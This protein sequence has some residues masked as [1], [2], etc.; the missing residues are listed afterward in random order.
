MKAVVYTAPHQFSVAQVPM[1]EPG[2]GRLRLRVLQSGLCGTDL[3]LDAGEFMAAFPMTPGHEVVGVVDALGDGVDRFAVGQQVT[4]NPNRACGHCDFCREGRPILC[5]N[6]TGLGTNLPGFFAEYAV[7]PADQVY[8]AEG[9]DPDLAVLTEP[10]SCAV[11]GVETAA[12]RPGSSALVIG[13]GPTGLLLSQ[14]LAT[15]GATRVAVA[16]P[17]RFKLDTAAAL[18]ADLVIE[19]PRDGV[20][21]AA[22][23]GSSPTGDGFDLVVEATGSAAV[24]QLCVPLTR[25]GGTT[26][27]Y[28][29][30]DPDAAFSVN[31]YDVFRREISVKGSFAEITSFDA[32]L[33]ALRSGRVRGGVGD[34]QLI[35]HRFALDDYGA[36]L[37][38]LRS[39]KTAHKIII[40]P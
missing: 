24:A 40:E 9:L 5:P 7:A 18:G 8:D 14:L 32:A 1:P 21:V 15:G 33:A 35:T 2:P 12:V 29:V 3:H 37:Q 22:L 11:H 19:I 27:I 17:T 23:R 34:Q 16:A 20:D 36:A 26:L 13:A 25:S 28:G 4:V 30:A 10:T 6:M 39:D 38:A 31:P